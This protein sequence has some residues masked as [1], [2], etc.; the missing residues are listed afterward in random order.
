MRHDV[1]ATKEI[2][3]G[4]VDDDRD[5]DAEI[6]A[7]YDTLRR[8]MGVPNLGRSHA[9]GIDRDRAGLYQAN[10][11]RPLFWAKTGYQPGHKVAGGSGPL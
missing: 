4:L 5:L 8:A 3:C 6:G 2:Q 9:M 10:A 1:D 7:A 11:G